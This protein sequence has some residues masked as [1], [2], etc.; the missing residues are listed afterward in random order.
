LNN[1]IAFVG[2]HSGGH[3]IPALTLAHDLIQ[4]NFATNLIFFCTNNVLD[5]AIIQKNTLPLMVFKLPLG[6]KN[7]TIGSALSLLFYLI[8]SF[9]Y[10]LY[11]LKKYHIKKVISMGGIVSLPVCFAAKILNIC[12]EIYELNATPGQANKCIAPIA[13]CIH[14]CFPSAAQYFAAQKTTLTAYP[15]RYNKE[16]HLMPKETACNTIHFSPF[17]TTIF[18]LGGSQGSLFLNNFIKNWIKH[19]PQIHQYIQIIHQT[20]H[21]DQQNWNAFYVQC[22]IQA[23]CFDYQENIHTYYN[24]ADI[25]ICRSGAGTLFESLFFNKQIYTVPLETKT[26]SHQK[27]NAYA[28]QK[29]Y[30]H[31]ITVITQKNLEHEKTKFFNSLSAAVKRE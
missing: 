28:L 8:Y 17:K 5:L 14:I 16:L 26:P 9:I 31:L 11:V 21:Y 25:I 15:I 24:A 1:N 12:I 13:T 30:P 6:K 29:E 18:V 2:G 7:S 20:G 19:D 4:K 10:S 23:I 3:I 27:D 22:A